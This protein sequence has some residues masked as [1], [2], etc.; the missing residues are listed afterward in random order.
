[1]TFTSGSSSKA[2]INAGSSSTTCHAR[3]FTCNLSPS[4]AFFRSCHCCSCAEIVFS[5]LWAAERKSVCYLHTL[6]IHENRCN[7]I[8]IDINR[9][10]FCPRYHRE[11]SAPGQP[12]PASSAEVLRLGSAVLSCPP[13][14]GGFWGTSSQLASTATVLIRYLQ[15]QS[16]SQQ[17]G[18]KRRDACKLGT[19]LPSAV[20]M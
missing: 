8:A 1:M 17:D 10:V 4:L 15:S 7:T 19:P 16:R 13:M 5:C 6:E 20:R 12:L 11:K 9:K 18:N 3:A 14:V 2:C